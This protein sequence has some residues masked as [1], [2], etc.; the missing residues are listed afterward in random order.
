MSRGFGELNPE[1]SGA[2]G[3]GDDPAR[4]GIGVMVRLFL[5]ISAGVPDITACEG[6]KNKMKSV[7]NQRNYQILD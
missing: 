6:E 2:E 4:I 3:T 7:I 1:M 5:P